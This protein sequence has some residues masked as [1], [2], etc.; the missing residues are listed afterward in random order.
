[1][2][3]S[4]AL[5]R[6]SEAIRRGGGAVTF[7]AAQAAGRPHVLGRRAGPPD[8][9][10]RYTV[11]RPVGAHL[12]PRQGPPVGQVAVGPGRCIFCFNCSAR[13]V[14]IYAPYWVPSQAKCQATQ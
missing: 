13:D 4:L 1:M 8:R 9:A 12:A 5:L 7:A 14:G 11:W 10:V 6:G 2:K 3:H